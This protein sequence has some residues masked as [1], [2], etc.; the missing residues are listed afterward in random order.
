MSESIPYR[1]GRLYGRLSPPGRLAVLAAFGIGVVWLLLPS[2]DTPSAS[3]APP[4]IVAPTASHN[5]PAPAPVPAPPNPGSQWL[6][7]HTPDPMSDGTYHIAQVKSSNTVNFDFPY[8]GEQRA[9]LTLLLSPRP[10]NEVIFEIEKGQVL[11]KSYADCLVNVRFDDGKAEYYSAVGASDGSTTG[12]YMRDYRKFVEKMQRAQRVRIAASI[13][14]QGAPT[15]EFDVSGY[16][17]K[18]HKPKK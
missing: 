5:P 16:D 12:I 6:Y 4:K 18:H 9:K 3:T 7:G 17:L 10:A 14:Q 11:C 8:S 1:L 13:Y 15:F 2:S